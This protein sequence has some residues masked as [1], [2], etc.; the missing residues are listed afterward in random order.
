MEELDGLIRA[1]VDNWRVERMAV[2]DRNV[3]RLAL[4][5]LLERLDQASLQA[6]R[7]LTIDALWHHAAVN[8]VANVMRPYLESVG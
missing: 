8:R 7:K 2:V 5:E 4:F 3:I 6:Q 1:G